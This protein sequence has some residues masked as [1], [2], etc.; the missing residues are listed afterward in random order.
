[1]YSQKWYCYFLNRIIRFCLPVHTLIY[2]WEIYIFLW[3]V[4]LFCCREIC[5]PILGIY[6]INRS[7][8]HECK[9]WD[10]GSAISRKGIH[11]WDFPCSEQ[12]LEHHRRRQHLEVSWRWAINNILKVKVSGK[13]QLFVG[14]KIICPVGRKKLTLTVLRQTPWIWTYR[15]NKVVYR[16]Y[17]VLVFMLH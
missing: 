7:Q 15:S 5:G 1:M 3:A 9:N 4:C 17:T 6:C 13:E 11:K 2:L 8:T 10:W 14:S 16:P 12:T